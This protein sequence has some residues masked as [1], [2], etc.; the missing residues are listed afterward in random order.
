MKPKASPFLTVE[1]AAERIGVD[2][3]TVRFWAKHRGLPVVRLGRRCVRYRVEDLDEWA[4]GH[5][6]VVG[7]EDR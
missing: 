2:P 3:S 1:Q 7:A 5:R 6:V 4:A